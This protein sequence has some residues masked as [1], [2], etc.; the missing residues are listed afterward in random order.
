MVISQWL[1]PSG[2]REV[3]FMALGN[4][5]EDI[6]EDI[7]SIIAVDVNVSVDY[8]PVTSMIRLSQVGGCSMADVRKAI[9]EMQEVCYG[10][11]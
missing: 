8:N 4:M 11:R 5:F 9:E 7:P 1:T 6:S 3:G 10:D 2:M